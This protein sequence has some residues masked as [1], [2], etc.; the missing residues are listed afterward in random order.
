MKRENIKIVWVSLIFMFAG[1]ATLFGWKIHAPGILSNKFYDEI[2][3]TDGRI[4]LYIPPHCA[5]FISTEKG[6][7]LADPTT[8]FIG[9]A[10]A[11]MLLEAFQHSFSEF[12]F[13][14]IDPNADV[15]KQYQIPFVIVVDIREFYNKM[16]LKGQAVSII[17]EVWILNGDLQIVRHLEVVG[18]S[19]A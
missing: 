19:D 3:K 1:C 4:A 13:M 17:S 5:E 8:F 10:F 14:E 11:P 16:T 6:G 12:V 9:E 15:L 18:T 7:T 2:E